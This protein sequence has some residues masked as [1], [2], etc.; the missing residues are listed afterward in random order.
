[1]ALHVVIIE[2]EI[3]QNAGNIMRTC[4]CTDTVLHL[5]KPLGFSL[6]DKWVKRS[7]LD[8]IDLLKYHV[9]DS[10][11]EFEHMHPEGNRYFFTTKAKRSFTDPVYHDG[12]YLIFGKESAGIPMDL[13]ERHPN[14]WVRI[15]MYNNERMRSLNLSNSVAVGIYEA[16]RQIGVQDLR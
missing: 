10:F 14:Q 5:I 3:P 7:G 6:S 11:D 16:V 8:Y 4:V 13:L 15:P 1:M 9:Y 12:D 2:P